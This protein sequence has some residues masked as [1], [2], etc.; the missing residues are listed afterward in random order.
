MKEGRRYMLVRMNRHRR[1]AWAMASFVVALLCCITTSGQ[2]TFNGDDQAG[3][4]RSRDGGK[5]WEKV[6]GD[7]GIVGILSDGRENLIAAGN[8]IYYHSKEP[9]TEWTKVTLPGS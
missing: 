8:G 5:T 7:A 3:V 1:N 6:L 4:L 9:G 2:Q